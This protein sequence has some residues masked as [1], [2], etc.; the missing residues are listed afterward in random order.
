[1]LLERCLEKESKNRYHDIA[2]VRVDIQKALANPSG[3]FMMP[4]SAAKP[5]KQVRLSLPWVATVFV[6]GLIIA[7]LA[8]W[9]LKPSEPRRVIRLDHVLPEDQQFN[10]NPNGVGHTLAVSLDGT[11][12]VYSTSQGLYLRS[13]D[14][15]N[16]T[17]IS[18]T[19]DNPQSPFFS[20]DGQ[21]IGYWSQA[22]SKLKKISIRGGAPVTLCDALSISGAIWYADNTIV[23]ADTMKGV[24]R[25][26]AN[27]GVPEFFEKGTGICPQILP[28]GKSLLFTDVSSSQYRIIVRGLESGEQKTLFSGGGAYYL[29]TGHLVYWVQNNPNLFAVPFDLRKLDVTGGPTPIVE[30][31]DYFASSDSG[32]LIYIPSTADYSKWT[33]V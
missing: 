24:M 26:S 20:P 16:A 4:V 33:P 23:Y 21:W 29:P 14:Q 15:L 19:G 1:L 27:A 17:L 12:L 10:F 30:N 11:Q 9:K 7:G 28:D 18:G 2:D 5:R 13:L 3:V 32:T 25:V 6:L 8:V 31:A 22:D